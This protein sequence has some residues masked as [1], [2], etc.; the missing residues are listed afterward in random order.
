MEE[1][2]VHLRSIFL[3]IVEHQLFAKKS[4]CFFGVTRIEYIGHF[5]TAKRVSTDPQKIKVMKEWPTPSTL[6]QLSGFLGLASL[7]EVHTRFWYHCQASYL[8][9]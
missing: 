1:H 5:I 6:K 2:I 4:K 7:Q 9:H 8:P 3:K